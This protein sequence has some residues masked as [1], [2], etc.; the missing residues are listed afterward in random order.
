VSVGVEYLQS[1][2]DVD[3]YRVNVDSL[4]SATLFGGL[5]AGVGFVLRYDNQPVPGK[6]ELDTALTLNLVYTY[7]SVAPKPSCPEPPPCPSC[8]PPKEE[9]GG[10][11]VEKVDLPQVGAPAPAPSNQ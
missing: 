8:P 4:A 7:T 9:G 5:S 3:R 2:R 6:K 1:F 11:G 10:G